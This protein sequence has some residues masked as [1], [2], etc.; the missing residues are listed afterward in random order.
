MGVSWNANKV[1]TLPVSLITT[2]SVIL[3]APPGSGCAL[4]PKPGE[5]G[6]GGVK[7][8]HVGAP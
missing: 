1:V 4:N 7:S 2:G 3:P 6:M 8:N 5:L